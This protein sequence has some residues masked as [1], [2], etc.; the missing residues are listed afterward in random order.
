[1]GIPSIDQHHRFSPAAR[2]CRD[3]GQPERQTGSI[4]RRLRE[5]ITGMSALGVR[6][7]DEVP[8]G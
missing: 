6:A 8:D 2:S 5:R 1:M 3:I 7:R 4:V